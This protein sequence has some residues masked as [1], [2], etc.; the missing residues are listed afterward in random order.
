MCWAAV[1]GPVWFSLLFPATGRQKQPAAAENK[2]QQSGEG[3]AA[4]QVYLPNDVVA[5]S[6]FFAGVFF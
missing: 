5:M 4:Q 1:A 6:C 2:P 3:S